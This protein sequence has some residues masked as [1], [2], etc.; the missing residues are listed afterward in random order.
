MCKRFGYISKSIRLNSTL[1]PQRCT[2]Q[3]RFWDIQI[4]F[5]YMVR[6]PLVRSGTILIF[7]MFYEQKYPASNRV[8]IDGIDHVI[9]AYFTALYM[10]FHRSLQIKDSDIRRLHPV[11]LGLK[12]LGSHYLKISRFDQNY[13]L[14]FEG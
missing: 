6:Y 1:Q 10:C 4:H 11:V 5:I 7:L 2:H 8:H 3:R 14:V 9:S 13:V 12:H